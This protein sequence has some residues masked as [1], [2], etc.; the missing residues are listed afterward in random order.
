MA[1]DSRTLEILIKTL[2]D[3]KG[4]D[5]VKGKLGELGDSAKGAGSLVGELSS[6]IGFGLGGAAV[7]GISELVSQ[8]FALRD[9]EQKFA[10][11]VRNANAL[12][13]SQEVQWSG[14]ASTAGKFFDVVRVGMEILPTIQKLANEAAAAQEKQLTTMQKA[15]DFMVKGFIAGAGAPMPG[16]GPNADLDAR[17]AAESVAELSRVLKDYTADTQKAMQSEAEWA[18]ALAG[19]TAEAI[20][21]VEAKLA[22]LRQQITAIGDPQKFLPLDPKKAAD[23]V[24]KI[25]ELQRE[26]GV[27]DQRRQQLV[28]TQEKETE[29]EDADANARRANLVLMREQ[30]TVLQGIRQQQELISANP[31]MGADEKQTALLNSSVHE[32]QLL[33][34][35]I[36]QTKAAMQ[37]SA[38]DPAQYTQLN[39]KLQQSVFE[40][41]LLGLK[42]A[43]LKHP[44]TTELIQWT[45]Q[46]VSASH[47]AATALTSTLGTAINSTSQALTGLIFHTGNWRQTMSQAAQSIVAD[48][49]R[50]A[51]QFV[52]SRTIMF[53]INKA[54]GSQESGVVERR[55]R[56]RNRPSPGRTRPQ[57]AQRR[58]GKR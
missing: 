3:T 34:G 36:Q 53:I 20:T 27:W 38:L 6:L 7:A 2:A 8:F 47:Q 4:V 32:M 43:G 58:P 23:A 17:K 11:Q 25:Q 18:R 1:I 37:N 22:D 29:G 9:E 30:A 13:T 26:Y 52:I 16:L 24:A 40:F 15:Y 41:N 28:K 31:F 56:R 46:F 50:I 49:I 19:P 39:Q 5:E 12:L 57:N 54:F 35:I 44:F 48:L 55:R 33:S 21:T 14:L 10:E 45:N 42:V 51:L